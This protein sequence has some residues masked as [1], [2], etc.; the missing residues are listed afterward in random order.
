MVE[1]EKLNDEDFRHKR[2]PRKGF[3]RGDGKVWESGSW[4]TKESVARRRKQKLERQQEYRDDPVKKNM[5]ILENAKSMPRLFHKNAAENE[6]GLTS[7][8]P[9]VIASTNEG[10]SVAKEPEKKIQKALVKSNE[11]GT[12]GIVNMQLEK[13][14]NESA[15]STL[16]SDSIVP[17]SNIEMARSQ[18]MSLIDSTATHLFDLMKSMTNKSPPNDLVTR[19]PE[20]VFAACATAKQIHDLMKLKLDAIKEM[21]K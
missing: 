5:L 4:R 12:K 8:N 21:R 16:Q 1:D 6:I 15:N 9:N 13:Q 2:S 7:L 10:L 19:D 14:M 3:V 18:S 17:Y 11:I 20:V